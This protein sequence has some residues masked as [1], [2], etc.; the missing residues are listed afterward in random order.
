MGNAHSINV[1]VICARVQFLL[2]MKN[3]LGNQDVDENE[4]VDSIL[5]VFKAIL[6]SYKTV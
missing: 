1:N 3:M 5:L 6:S 2:R 4:Y